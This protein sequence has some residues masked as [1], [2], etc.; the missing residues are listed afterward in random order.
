YNR[1]CEIKNK[2]DPDGVFTPNGFCVGASPVTRYIDDDVK[3]LATHLQ[4]SSIAR[5]TLVAWDRVRSAIG[6]S[7][8]ENKIPRA[9][10]QMKDQA[11]FLNAVSDD[12]KMG[13]KLRTRQAEQE[14][15]LM[16]QTEE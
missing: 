12:R 11:R 6:I 8:L 10:P 2:V 16:R 13:A 3:S 5:A 9:D 14:Q 4:K 15:K 1:L 7:R